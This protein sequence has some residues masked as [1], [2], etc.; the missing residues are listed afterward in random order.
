MMNYSIYHLPFSVSLFQQ[1]CNN[2]QM[3][4]QALCDL[5]HDFEQSHL[6]ELIHYEADL[7]VTVNS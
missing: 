1:R 5:M 2:L 4:T 3:V 7:L 6:N